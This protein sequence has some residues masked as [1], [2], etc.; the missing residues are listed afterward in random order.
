MKDNKKYKIKCVKRK[1]SKTY[2]TEVCG[3]ISPKFWKLK[4]RPTYTAQVH[5][6]INIK[7]QNWV[8]QLSF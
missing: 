7:K 3:N 8:L 6:T 4:Y 5:V 1:Y 2:E